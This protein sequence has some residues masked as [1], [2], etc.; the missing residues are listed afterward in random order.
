MEY[1]RMEQFA[2]SQILHLSTCGL[3]YL[4]MG[5]NLLIYVPK[6]LQCTALNDI[7]FPN[8]QSAITVTLRVTH[9]LT[10]CSNTAACRTNKIIPY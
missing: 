4:Y 10:C 1:E 3:S 7:L 6:T 9:M 8:K 2:P 5:G